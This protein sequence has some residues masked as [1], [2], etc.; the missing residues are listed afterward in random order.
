MTNRSIGQYHSGFVAVAERI[1]R[2]NAVAVSQ[3]QAVD[4]QVAANGQQSVRLS[5]SRIGK[6]YLC[7]VK[8]EKH[9][10]YISKLFLSSY[11]GVDYKSAGLA[12]SAYAVVIQVPANRPFVR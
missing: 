10:V 8:S 4:A 1:P 3:Q 2:E 6:G 11:A 5:E 12:P 9:N 7:I